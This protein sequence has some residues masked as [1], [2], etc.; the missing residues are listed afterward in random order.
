MRSFI[1]IEE[2]AKTAS[3]NYC[4]KLQ[5]KLERSLFLSAF[6]VLCQELAQSVSPDLSLEMAESLDAEIPS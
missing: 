2:F 1:G 6:L 3:L 5:I 4:K